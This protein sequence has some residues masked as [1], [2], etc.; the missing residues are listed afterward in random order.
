MRKKYPNP[1][2]RTFIAVA[3]LLTLFAAGTGYFIPGMRLQLATVFG[4][5]KQT[6]SDLYFSYANRPITILVVPG[7][8]PKN[9]G[10]SFN[11]LREAD[12][13]A[14]LG[15]KLVTLF[16]EDERFRVYT[17][18][19]TFGGYTPW[20][21]NYLETY[22]DEITLFK[23]TQY[24]LSQSAKES[25]DVERIEVVGH[26]VAPS[27]TLHALYGIN[28]WANDDG[29][30]IVLHLHF[31]DY[32]GR[33]WGTVGKYTGF[34][35][36]IPEPQLPNHDTSNALATNLRYVFDDF[37]TRSTLPNESTGIIP[38]QDLIAVGAHGTRDGA[39]LLI[40]YGYIYETPLQKATVRDTYL[41]E[42]A[43]QTYKGV[44]TFFE[45]SLFLARFNTVPYTWDRTLTTNDEGSDVLALQIGLRNAGHYPPSGHS[46]ATCPISG[47]FGSCTAQA[48]RELQEQYAAIVLSP[49]GL[50]SPTNVAGTHTFKLLNLTLTK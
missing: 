42:L 6:T 15:A 43:Y 38:D 33:R 20:F 12:I 5:P 23:Q 11:N 13:N 10:T 28:K 29:V 1:L 24:N 26:N 36:Y 37:I 27:D 22:R 39:S 2:P 16:E 35:I 18:H 25:G 34:S 8:D 47:Y 46:L 14:A 45:P 50:T 17:T 4:A 3:L 44:K 7:H 31:N 30:D 19:N 32:G 9:F 49:L 41:D 21:A 40:E 48:V